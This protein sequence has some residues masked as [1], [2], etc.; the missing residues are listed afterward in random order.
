[1]IAMIAVLPGDGIGP[2]VC[3]QA[4]RILD[5]VGASAGHKFEL[6][7]GLLGGQAI[8]QTGAPL[9]GETLELCR[10]ADAVL[11]GAVG[12]PRFDGAAVRPEA[13]LLELRSALELSANLRPIKAHPQ[14]V[15][16]S[17]LKADVLRDVDFVIVRELTGG[18][19]YGDRGRED[20]RAFDTCVYTRAEIERVVRVAADIARSRKGALTSIDKANVLET[21]RL[22]RETVTHVIEQDYPDVTLEHR[23][24]DAAAMHLVTQ[25]SSLDVVV[26]EN[27]FGDILSDE[28]SVLAGS[29]GMLPSASLGPRRGGLYE[30][31]HGSAPDIAGLGVANPMGAILSVAMLLRHSLGLEDEAAAVE[32]AVSDTLDC[33]IATADVGVDSPADTWEVGTA[34]LDRLY[35]GDD[36]GGAPSDVVQEQS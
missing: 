20:D 11:V 14:L 19:Y 8:D 30:P 27:M 1:M 18:L 25:P 2:E 35:A 24:V 4:T 29:L 34:V 32:Q 12:A 21:S 15:E 23:L 28:A 26:T 10:T 31:V 16:A 6:H 3:E 7:Y 13:G 22:W 17:P 33:G 9:P 5:K 36:K